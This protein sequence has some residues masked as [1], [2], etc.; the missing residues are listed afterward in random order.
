MSAAGA[1]LL[2]VVAA[3]GHAPPAASAEMHHAAVVID[4]G[5]GKVRKFCLAFPE[6]SVTGAEALR[7]ID[8]AAVFATYGGK[9]EAVCSLCGVGCPSGECFCDRSKYWAYHRAGPGG[10]AYQAS[11]AGVSATTV[12]DGDVEGWRWGGGDAPPPATVGEVCDVAE[13]PSRTAAAT[14]TST[15][16]ASSTSTSAPPAGAAP[17]PT[18]PSPT[19]PPTAPARV[20]PAARAGTGSRSPVT[21]TTGPTVTTV[22]DGTGASGDAAGGAS[23]HPEELAGPT[24][25]TA[26][27]RPVAATEEP[28]RSPAAVVA[29]AVVLAGMTVA[30][31]RFRRANLRK[32]TD[33]R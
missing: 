7:R 15:T 10:G 24:V 18:S 19:P 27:T 31:A 5:D 6:E 21:T 8:A 16:P 9:G 25:P 17:P 1:V 23:S 33:L 2:A 4:T 20:G 29:F 3:G 12:R 13:P 30:F 28:G 32:A 11:R 22:G 14:T 26:N